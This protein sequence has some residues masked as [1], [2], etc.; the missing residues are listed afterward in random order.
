VIN[1]EMRR[2]YWPDSRDP[3]GTRIHV[4]A[5]QFNNNV[6]MTPPGSDQWLEVIGVVGTALNEGLRESPSPALYLP[7][8]FA[9]TPHCDFL[10]RT[11]SDPHLLIRAI[12]E[13]VSEIEPSIS[14][15]DPL[16][17]DEQLGDFDR[18][19]P[20]FLAALFTLF[21]GVAALALAA[22]GL[23]SV[24]SY[25]V[26]RR[27]RE[28]GIRIALGATNGDVLALVTAS[29]ARYAAAGLGTGLLAS[30][31]ALRS[32]ARAL[33]D[34]KVTDPVPFAMVIVVFIPI[35]ALACLIPAHKAARIAP[36]SALR[37]D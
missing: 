34:W 31:V 6:V 36:V 24:I 11:E 14:P 18:A 19:L 10:L 9:L 5:L 21:G 13:R 37:H 20:R 3:I 23:Y 27:T 1:D 26:E 16:T 15:G 25:G 4:P 35:G 29:T 33:P 17:L 2:R 7:Y 12:K 22:T 32:I 8:K 28:L 30:I